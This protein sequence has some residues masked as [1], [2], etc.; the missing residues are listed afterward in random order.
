MGSIRPPELGLVGGACNDDS[1]RKLFRWYD[2]DE[3]LVPIVCHRYSDL[4]GTSFRFTGMSCMYY[5]CRSSL[6]FRT[7]L[8]SFD[9]L[10][11]FVDNRVY[12]Y[13]VVSL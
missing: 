5:L 9:F 1:D 10:L 8:F 3:I 7:G 4:R 12:V 2:S 11:F 6:S 13:L